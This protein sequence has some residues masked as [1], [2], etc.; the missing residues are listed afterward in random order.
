[1]HAVPLSQFTQRHAGACMNEPRCNHT[2][3]ID[4]DRL[5]PRPVVSSGSA[6]SLLDHSVAH[7]CLQQQGHP[8][9]VPRSCLRVRMASNVSDSACS[10]IPAT[11]EF[12][13]GAWSI[14]H[15]GHQRPVLPNTIE[16]SILLQH[17]C[18]KSDSQQKTELPLPLEA[19][20]GWMQYAQGASE[21]GMCENLTLQH[22][23]T[24]AQVRC[25]ALLHGDPIQAC[26]HHV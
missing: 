16:R 14:G 24:I 13:G 26:D 20:Q 19:M 3:A 5:V 18:A 21:P 7:L 1:M 6:A 8:D 17:I 22:L 23:C 25:Y 15:D 2:T 10:P 4:N 12:T 9:C 11:L